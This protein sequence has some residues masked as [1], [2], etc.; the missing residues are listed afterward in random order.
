MP[1]WKTNILLITK[2]FYFFLQIHRHPLTYILCF[3]Q[4]LSSFVRD[5]ANFQPGRGSFKL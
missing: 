5:S 3:A 2:S 1:S 4:E